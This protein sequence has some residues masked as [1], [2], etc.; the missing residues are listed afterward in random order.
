MCKDGRHYFT[1]QTKVVKFIAQRKGKIIGILY[2]GKLIRDE[3]KIYNS[4]LKLA[5]LPN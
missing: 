2:D 5:G 1:S 4:G 3:I